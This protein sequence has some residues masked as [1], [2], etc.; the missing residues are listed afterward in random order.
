M[1][2]IAAEVARLPADKITLD[3]E[4]VVRDG[5][6]REDFDARII[7]FDLLQANEAARTKDARLHHQ[8]QGGATRNRPDFRVF[9]VEQSDCFVQRLRLRQLERYHVAL[10]AL[11]AWNL[12]W[13]RE[14]N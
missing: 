3:G 7:R 13:M 1:P 6:G 11:V 10:P 9:R 8:H 5:D 2:A 12:A 4:V 14:A